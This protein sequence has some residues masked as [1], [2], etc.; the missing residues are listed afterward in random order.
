[1]LDAISVLVAFAAPLVWLNDRYIGLS[2]TISMMAAGVLTALF[3]SVFEMLGFSGPVEQLNSGLE[4]ID[5]GPT[6]MNVLIGILLYV[7]ALKINLRLFEQQH[8]LILTLAVVSTLINTVLTGAAT[9]ALLSALG[10]E[11]PFVHC[12]LF[13]ALISPTDPIATVAILKS[14]GLPKKLEVVIEGESLLNDGVGAVAF[15]ILL[16]IVVTGH[17]PTVSQVS[18]ELLRD[19]GGGLVLG[20][21]LGVIGGAMARANVGLTSL[22]LVSMAVILFGGF[23][24]RSLHVSYPLAMVAAGVAQASVVAGHTQENTQR[25]LD[26]FKTVDNVLVAGL[27]LLL[28]LFAMSNS[29]VSPH[30]LAMVL[31]IPL[32]LACRYVSVWFGLWVDGRGRRAR[33]LPSLLTWGGLRGGISVALAL[34]IPEVATKSLLQDMS[35]AVVVFSVLVQAPTISRLFKTKTLDQIVEELSDERQAAPDARTP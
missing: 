33:Q 34:S 10:F 30:W 19:V 28:G 32:V 9:W 8:V 29:T 11:A 12:L 1:M 5:F 25:H 35:Y 31:A 27:F 6:L 26:F 16:G 22:V 4:A 15:A 2:T 24:A 3:F 21:V 18:W 20:V 7:A 23:A 13:G 14:V 17:E